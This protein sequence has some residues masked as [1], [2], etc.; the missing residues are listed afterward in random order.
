MK[1][2]EISNHKEAKWVLIYFEYLQISN[3]KVILSNL[4]LNPLSNLEYLHVN[5]VYIYIYI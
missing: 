1:E 5:K 2:K 3:L 4:F